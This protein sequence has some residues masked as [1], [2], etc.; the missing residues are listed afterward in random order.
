MSEK[1]EQ[2]SSDLRCLEKQALELLLS[3]KKQELMKVRFLVSTDPNKLDLAFK[4]KF[5]KK[6]IARVSTIITEKKLATDC[7][8]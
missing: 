6:F 5:L 8:S 4:I 1:N 3:E 7:A 2:T